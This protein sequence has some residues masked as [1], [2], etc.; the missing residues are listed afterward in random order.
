M[1]S[2]SMITLSVTRRNAPQMIWDSPAPRGRSPLSSCGIS[3]F[4]VRK[5]TANKTLRI[6]WSDDTD[7]VAAFYP[8]DKS[9]CQVVAQHSKLKDVKAGAKM[10]KFW[11]EALDRLKQSL[12]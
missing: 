9:K 5:S 11:A 4:T 2:C 10:K 8:K 6:T 1:A 7:V 3:D 12:E